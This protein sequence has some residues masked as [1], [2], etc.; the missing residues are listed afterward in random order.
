MSDLL[1]G[2]DHDDGAG[3]PPSDDILAGEYVLGVLDGDERRAVEA[4]IEAEP[5]FARLVAEWEQRLG[6]MASSIEPLDVPEHLWPRI[7]ERLGWSPARAPTPGFWRSVGFWRAATAV[8]AAVAIAAIVVRVPRMRAPP[9][10]EPVTTLARDNGMPS[11]LAS[12]DARDSTLLVV[13]VPSAPDRGGRVPELWLIAP[14]KAPRPLGLLSSQRTD[15]I[16]VPADLRA[17][18]TSGAVLAVSLEPPGG[19]PHGAPTGPIVAKGM[20]EL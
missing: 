5:I 7:R 11:W 10:A 17:S 8:A 1:Q 18:L 20:I 6:P 12:L 4:R 3:E 13:P 15:S 2:P 19:A 16:V 9:I 14:G